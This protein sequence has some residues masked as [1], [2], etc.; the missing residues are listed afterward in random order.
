MD[1]M[2]SMQQLAASSSQHQNAASGNKHML[3][4]VIKKKQ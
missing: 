3:A 2:P 4:A 1:H